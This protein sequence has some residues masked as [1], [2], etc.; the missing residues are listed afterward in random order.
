MQAWT[1]QIGDM[2]TRVWKEFLDRQH[3]EKP[4]EIKA[5]KLA[6]LP[7]FT[8]IQEYY[9]TYFSWMVQQI[10]ETS[11]VSEK[12]KEDAKCAFSKQLFLDES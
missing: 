5:A 3:S 6:N 2:N 4:E 12:V 1:E 9:K 11:G 8:W 7:Y 10:R